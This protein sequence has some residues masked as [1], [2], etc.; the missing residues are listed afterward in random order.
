MIEVYK[1]PERV[2]EYIDSKDE[3]GFFFQFSFGGTHLYDRFYLLAIKSVAGAPYSMGFQYQQPEEGPYE[4]L[5]INSLTILND[6]GIILFDLMKNINKDTLEL[7]FDSLYHRFVNF[8]YDKKLNFSKGILNILIN[9]S[10][11]DSANIYYDREYRLKYNVKR[12][13]KMHIILGN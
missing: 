2:Y 12:H 3:Y 13:R 9:I 6:S 5:R 4:K 10:L 7:T 11:V 8:N 1:G